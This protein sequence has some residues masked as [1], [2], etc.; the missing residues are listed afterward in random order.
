[1][2]T[3]T[4]IIVKCLTN[5]ASSQFNSTITT[6]CT[7]FDLFNFKLKS[8]IPPI[9]RFRK[10]LSDWLATGDFYTLISGNSSCIAKSFQ[11]T[12]CVQLCCKK[13]CQL[14]E[15]EAWSSCTGPCASN[16]TR[17]RTRAV[18][19]EATCGGKACGT[20]K[21]DAVCATGCCSADCKLREFPS[22][23]IY[24]RMKTLR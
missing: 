11:P 10:S 16:G 12:K 6:K 14:S 9:K 4:P 19:Q 18:K 3:C 15:W 5:K 8:A 24:E 17:S 23:K 22:V 20:L 21:E 7:Y 2:S 1:M 13:D